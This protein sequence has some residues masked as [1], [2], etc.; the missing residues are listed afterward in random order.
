MEAVASIVKKERYYLD[1]SVWNGIKELVF[2]FDTR[3]FFTMISRNQV[4]CLYSEIVE[5]ELEGAPSVVRE[6]FGSVSG[7]YKE[8]VTITDDILRLA[9]VYIDRGVVGR[10]SFDDCI[11]IAAATV[12]KADILVS[13]NFKHIVNIRRVRGYNAINAEFG[14]PILEIRSPRE[15]S[16]YAL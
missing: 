2:A 8:K 5:R 7:E 12:H 15:V 1:T 10:T 13:W 6:V 16:D 14:Y 4:V 9:K 3:T 11:H